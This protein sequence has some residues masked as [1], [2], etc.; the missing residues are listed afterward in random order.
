MD[1]KTYYP[2][3]ELYYHKTDGGAEYLTDSWELNPDG[4]KGG[5]FM[6]AK[7]IVRIDGIPT[8]TLADELFA[9]DQV[10]SA[11]A[12]AKNKN[13]M[14]SKTDVDRTPVDAVAVRQLVR[15]AVRA[16]AELNAIRAR[17]GV[18]YTHEGWKS[19]VDEDYFSS[20]VD[21][22]DDAVKSATGKSAHC[23][24]ELYA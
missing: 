20:V 21:G 23:H 24:P 8:V 1:K 14:D 4:S 22:L 3:M 9:R 13:D 17:D 11:G 12:I 18:P 7:I 16:F 6:D 5:V 2:K 19:G 10:R 15:A